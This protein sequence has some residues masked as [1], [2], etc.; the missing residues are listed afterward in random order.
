MSNPVFR[1]T[2]IRFKAIEQPAGRSY[3]SRHIEVEAEIPE[4][5]SA[6]HALDQI[7]LAVSV[8][9]GVEPLR[10]EM[11]RM[12]LENTERASISAQQ[13][14]KQAKSAATVAGKTLGKVTAI[15]GE[16]DQA[17]AAHDAA[18]AMPNDDPEAL[19]RTEHAVVQKE[20]EL[21]EFTE[22][23]QW[24][25]REQERQEAIAKTA[26]PAGVL[27]EAREN[28]RKIIA[29]VELAAGRLPL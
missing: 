9:L 18:L 27:E 24:D 15:T 26:P 6:A 25:L 20:R 2:R 12:H 29:E 22:Q 4:G 14:S 3:A 16:R 23:L 19:A 13:A 21:R 8:R 17:L 10:L 5:A 28:V 7:D 1:I 11:A